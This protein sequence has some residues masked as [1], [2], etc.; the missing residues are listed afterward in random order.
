MEE[1]MVEFPVSLRQK[2]PIELFIKRQQATFCQIVAPLKHDLHSWDVRRLLPALCDRHDI[3]Y[4]RVLA[5]VEDVTCAITPHATVTGKV[6]GKGEFTN[7][8]DALAQINSQVIESYFEYSLYVHFVNDDIVLTMP[9]WSG[10]VRSLELIYRDLFKPVSDNECDAEVLQYSDVSQW[11]NDTFQDADAQ[12]QRSLWRQVL[13]ANV[14]Q[15]SFFAGKKITHHELTFNLDESPDDGTLTSRLLLAWSRVVADRHGLKHS[16]VGIYSPGR[17][18]EE[19]GDIVGPFGRQ[20]PFSLRSESQCSIENYASTLEQDIA[21]SRDVEEYFDWTL[22]GDD[23]G[24][25]AV[26]FNSISLSSAGNTENTPPAGTRYLSYGSF[27]LLSLDVVGF[28]SKNRRVTLKIK[29]STENFS[30]EDCAVIRDQFLHVYRQ[31]ENDGKAMLSDI[32]YVNDDHRNYIGMWSQGVSKARKHS[33]FVEA[34]EYV[35]LHDPGRAAVKCREAALSYGE[36]NARSNRFANLMLEARLEPGGHVGICLRRSPEQI[37]SML[38]CLKLGCV[39]VP[40]DPAHPQAHLNKIIELADLQAIVSTTEFIDKVS[41]TPYELTLLDWETDARELGDYS[42]AIFEPVSVSPAQGA[43]IVFTSGTTGEPKGVKVPHKALQNY[44]EG[45]EDFLPAAGN[46]SVAALATVAADLGFTAVFGALGTGRCLRILAEELTL[47]SEGLAAELARE[48]VDCL[49]IVPTHLSALLNCSNPYNILPSKSLILGGESAGSS[50]IKK[51]RDLRP[52][53]RIINHYGP[54]ETT[55]G[56]ACNRLDDNRKE[57]SG[58]PIGVIGT[59]LPN[60]QCYVL[61]EALDFAGVNI[62]GDLYLS[63]ENVADGYYGRAAATAAVFVPNPFSGIAGSRMYRSGDRALYNAEGKLVYLGRKDAQ[64]KI[65]GHRVELPEIENVVKQQFELTEFVVGVVDIEGTRRLV[66]YLLV[67]DSDKEPEIK[68]YLHQRMPDYM[69]PNVWLRLEKLPITANGKLDRKNLPFPSE[70]GDSVEQE[71]GKREDRNDTEQALAGLFENLLH[72]NSVSLRDN[73]F[74]LGGDSITAIQLVA[75]ARQLGYQIKPRQVFENPTISQLA[76]IAIPVLNNSGSSS[77]VTGSASL[78]PSQCRFLHNVDVDRHHYNQAMIYD[79]SDGFDDSILYRSL[80]E[81]L[82]HH[83]ALRTCFTRNEQGE[84]RQEFAGYSRELLDACYEKETIDSCCLHQCAE[85]IKQIVSDRQARFAL[86]Q[87]PLVRF[88]HVKLNNQ[89]INKLIVIAHHLVVDTVSFSIIEGD[90]EYLIDNELSGRNITLP[91][92]SDSFKSWVETLETK[93]EEAFWREEEPYWHKTLGETVLLPMNREARNNVGNASSRIIVLN[94][95]LSANVQYRA[96]IA[97]NG[98][99][100]DIL[101]TALCLAARDCSQSN[102]LSLVLESNGRHSGKIAHDNSRTVGW[103]TSMFPVNLTVVGDDL[104]G[105]M[106][107]VKEQLRA[108]PDSGIGYTA[109]RFLAN[110]NFPGARE[111][112]ICFNYFGSFRGSSEKNRYLNASDYEIAQTNSRSAVQ[113][114]AFALEILGAHTPE[115]LAFNFIYNAS[116]LD[117]NDI[118]ALCSSFETHLTRLAEACL[119][120][121]RKYSPSDFPELDITQRELDAILQ[122]TNI[123]ADDIH[124]IYPAT[125]VQCGILYHSLAMSGTGVYVPQHAIEINYD[126]NVSAFKEAWEALIAKHAI[127]RTSFITLDSDTPLQLVTKTAA[128]PFLELDWS[129][130]DPLQLEEAFSEVLRRQWLEEF[131]VSKAPLIRLCLVK[132]S[133]Q[134]YRFIWTY[135][136][137]IIDGWSGPIILKEVFDVYDRIEKN[138]P[139]ERQ[140]TG[141]YVEYIRWLKTKDNDVAMGF[142]RQYLTCYEQQTRLSDVF[143]IANNI[144]FEA[145]KYEVSLHLSENVCGEVESLRKQTGVTTSAICQAAWALLLKKYT[146]STDVLF[147]LT[148]SGRPSELEGV[149]TMVGQ[150]INTLPMRVRIDGNSDIANFLAY[151]QQSYVNCNEYA[152]IP[153]AKIRVAAEDKTITEFDTIVVFENYPTGQFADE[154]EGQEICRSLHSVSQNNYPLS[155]VIV[156]GDRL[157]LTLKY[158]PEKYLSAQVEEILDSYVIILEELAG[159]GTKTQTQTK[160]LNELSLVSQQDAEQALLWSRA[161]RKKIDNDTFIKAFDHWVKVHPGNTAIQYVGDQG[162]R[163]LSFA[164]LDIRANK[165][166]RYLLEEEFERRAQ[167]V[168]ALPR[169]VE[170]VVAIVASLKCGFSFVP[171]D[172]AIPK[173]RLEQVLSQVGPVAVIGDSESLCAVSDGLNEIIQINLDLEGQVIEESDQTNPGIDIHPAQLAYTIFTSGSTGE[174]KGVSVSHGALSNYIAGVNERLKLPEAANVTAL[175]TSAADLGYTALFG[176]LG[177]GRCLRLVD[178]SKSLDAEAIALEFEQFP[179]DCLKIVPSHLSALLGV[180]NPQRVLPEKCLVLGGESTPRDLITKVRALAPGLSIVNH[181][182]PTETTVGICTYTYAEEISGTNTI[183]RPLNNCSSYVLDDCLNPVGTG[184]EADIYLAGVNLAQGYHNSPRK[185][186]ENFLPDPHSEIPGCR[187]YLSGDRGKFNSDGNLVFCGRRDHQIKIR[188]YR[189]ELEEIRACLLSLFQVNN[190]YVKVIEINS[191]MHIVAYLCGSTEGENE[192]RERLREVL[193][194]YMQPG[195]I[196]C[197]DSLPLKGNGKIDPA[198]LPEPGAEKNPGSLPATETERKLAKIWQEKLSLADV[199]RE[200]KFF[201]IG[202]DSLLLMR[203]HQ[204]ILAQVESTIKITDLFKYSTISALGKYIDSIQMSD[205]ITT[206]ELSHDK[207]KKRASRMARSKQAA[208]ANRAMAIKNSIRKEVI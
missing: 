133:S 102:T 62:E 149:E 88:I 207:Q 119:N 96:P 69:Q 90:L 196:V 203:V 46:A 9:A 195:Y 106:L 117:D 40:L 19:L 66:A 77:L 91:G 34:F 24:Y 208:A 85:K 28:H 80:E 39:F 87:A 138:L 36:L 136:H 21:E 78:S 162:L 179:V 109:L 61:N 135:M 49:K 3:L 190:A 35:A 202:G 158:S 200:D 51:I 74:S 130:K 153:I 18:I 44:I 93:A 67:E 68:A 124:D 43:Y 89:S 166:A 101:L 15:K 92:K 32:S 177:S 48:P 57:N 59:A 71:T 52:D 5:D 70:V 112:D 55:I 94:K 31:C 143:G 10:D 168:I 132:L 156:P 115:G 98:Q 63:G 17:Q 148:V 139:L 45:V 58:I 169:G 116:M 41:D 155:L 84:W 188:G 180:P 42:E 50:L 191:R 121:G 110:S 172:S 198:A 82:K 152:H 30:K 105:H 54:T 107:S 2:Y 192:I 13:A 150:F 76:R 79:I 142:W 65:R 165:F 97:F 137:A 75:R 183:G 189:V 178:E 193:P 26:G 185:T 23:P 187:M 163:E 154:V 167:I 125:Q 184:I 123:T 111:P 201:E 164:E 53:L 170:Q 145:N 118:E 38:A 12:D 126:L 141:D 157:K 174:P 108:V 73:F 72:I 147:G 151:I 134:R 22:A 104:M 7:L 20:L 103:Y 27:N 37:I 60:N 204:T 144:P 186:A 127:F 128:V 81:I 131:D 194:D 4:S 64:T 16:L 181:Y 56:I 122:S 205:D 86:D 114:R 33:H 47:D 6:F 8:E 159:S 173:Y 95:E 83:D 29:A 113:E 140:S 160:R 199:F 171:I 146:Q 120:S 197:L 99:P 129:G 100:Q 161:A 176:A 11:L 175:A 1:F 182:G 206:P 14:D 25:C